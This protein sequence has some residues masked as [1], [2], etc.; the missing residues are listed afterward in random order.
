MGFKKNDEQDPLLGDARDRV[1]PLEPGPGDLARP[2]DAVD[3]D[4]ALG[5]FDELVV[6]QKPAM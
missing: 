2:E 4:R 5:P 6:G 3:V 1:L